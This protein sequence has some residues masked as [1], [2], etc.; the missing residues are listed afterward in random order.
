MKTILSLIA[1][2]S[3]IALAS[4]VGAQE[5]VKLTDGQMDRVTAGFAFSYNGAALGDATGVGVANLIT[6]TTT[7]TV[8]VADPTGTLAPIPP[9]CGIPC[10][11]AAGA[12]N[13]A[14]VSVFTPGLPVP[15]AA[16]QSTSTATAALF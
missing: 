15:N 2:A 1:G 13:V 3:M 10:A 16:A 14:S 7:G 6:T 4:G 9:G 11:Y 12:S 8:A 5:P